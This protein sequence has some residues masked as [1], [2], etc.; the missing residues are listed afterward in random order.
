MA[1]K[2]QADKWL[3]A[4]TAGLALFGIVMV[5]SASAVIATQENNN[6]Y[7]YVMKQGVWTLIGFAAMLAAMNFDY[8]RLRNRWIIYGLLASMVLMLVAVFAFPRI[9]GAHRWIRFAGF[10]LQPSEVS[11]LA[12][13]L[14]LAYF[15]EKRAGEER[16]FW[17]TFVPSI[18]VTG[19]L[20]LLVVAEPDLGTALMLL[21]VFAV[22]SYTAGARL[23]HLGM[24]AAPALLGLVGLLVFVP[25]RM[26]R[27]VMFLNPWAD[28]QGSGFQVVQ[29]LIAIG[30]GGLDGLGFA[31]G[32]QKM[33][34]LPF[35]HSDFI[36]AVVGE[37]LGL[38]GALMVVAVFGLFLWRGLR[39]AL[40]APDR[41]GM[42]LGLGI[43]AGVVTQALF[44]IS[45]VLSLVPT[46]G[47]PL[48]FIS[49]GGSSLVPT[50]VG[51]GILLNISQYA[52][53]TASSSGLAGVERGAAAAA[54]Q[55][56]QRPLRALPAK[57]A[58]RSS[59]V[60]WQPEARS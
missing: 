45:V 13:V 47:I 57:A 42:L 17:K 11:K 1:R 8:Q 24:A 53:A 22:I 55:Q 58:P 39:A 36:F 60:A 9:N 38:F 15:F 31:Q 5:Y 34:F 7:Y 16:S 14:F 54:E 48:P 59:A 20:A 30:S 32:R 37:E 56:Q 21:V 18:A 40:L 2:L 33:F 43:V 29:S 46:K 26:R 10:S 3:F 52:G 51:V 23:L 41:F 27:L 25:F 12:L 50:L 49:Y 35:A 6:Q 44:N 19:L 28:A 4:A